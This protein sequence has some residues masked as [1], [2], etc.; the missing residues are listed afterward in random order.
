MVDRVGQQFGD[1]RLIR[2]IGRG[3]FADVYLG[4]HIRRKSLAAVKV[5]H[6]RLANDNVKGFLNEARSFRLKHPHII[7]ILD[8]GLEDD[9]PYLVMDYA[10]NGSLRQRHPKGTQLPLEVIVGYVHQVAEALQYA[11]EE[12]VIHRDIKPDNMLLG[13]HDEVLLSDFGIASIAHT[14]HSMDI[15]D[16]AGTINYMAPEQLQGKPRPASDQYA[17]GIVVYEWICGERPF[18]GTFVE[19][20]GQHLSTPPSSL[21]ER[22]PSLPPAVEEVVPNSLNC[23]SNVTANHRVGDVAKSVT[24]TGTVTCTEEVYDQQAAFALVSSALMAEAAKDPGPGYVLVGTIVIGLAQPPTVDGKQ[25]VSLIIHAVGVWAYQFTDM[26]KSQ[27]ANGITNNSK[28]QALMYLQAAAGVSAV[29]IDISRGNILP[30]AG[31]IT[32]TI[33]PV[34]GAPGTPTTTPGSATPGTTPTSA[35]IHTPTTGLGGS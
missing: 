12:G 4:E 3:G 6:A 23:T 9:F 24:V 2:L 17:L 16:Q 25:A 20:H 26:I 33:N 22:V 35:P 10:P 1:Y 29:T 34:P 27:L 11:H 5:L 7:Q 14:T 31:H 19:I 30:D 28:D 18:R 15:Q 32:I 13:Q 21:R 8:F